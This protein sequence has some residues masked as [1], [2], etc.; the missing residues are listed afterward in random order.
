VVIIFYLL[1]TTKF[2][3]KKWACV[4]VCPCV[5]GQSGIARCTGVNLCIYGWKG[6][7]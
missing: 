2:E 4:C 7:V 5:R 3:G 6:G 1:E